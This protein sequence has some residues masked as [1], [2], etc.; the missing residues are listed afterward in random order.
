[1]RKVQKLFGFKAAL[2]EGSIWNHITQEY[3]WIDIE[4]GKIYIY[5]PQKQV[6]RSITTGQKVGTIVPTTQ[7][8]TVLAALQDGIY[9]VDT[10]TEKMRLLIKSPYPLEEMRFND[11]KCDPLGRFWIGSM[12]LNGDMYKAVLYSYVQN[13]DLQPRM[14]GVTTSNGICWSSDKKQM[15]Y[16]DTPERWVKAFDFDHKTG[17]I[18]NGRIIIDFNEINGSPDGMAIDS[19]GKLWVALWGGASVVR[20]DPDNGSLLDQI[21]IPAKN[22]TSCTFGGKNLDQLFITT[23]RIGMN[24][25]DLKEYPESGSVFI[26]NPQVSGVENNFFNMNT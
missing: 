24:E 8:N 3:L 26:V 25:N 14:Q 17:N 20:Y 4:N 22:V 11:G 1:M 7:K 16:I 21:M 6:I 15:Y 10:V 2:G 5:H 13:E 9:A 19:E 12:S 18:T 23:A